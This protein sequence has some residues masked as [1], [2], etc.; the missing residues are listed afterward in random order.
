VSLSWAVFSPFILAIFVPLMKRYS[1]LHIGWLVS[2]LPLALFIGFLSY[3]PKVMNGETVYHV[4]EWIPSLGINIAFYLD[5]LSLLFAMIITGIGFFV[6]IYSIGY[7]GAKENLVNFYIYILMFMGAMLG[8]VLSN[9]L[10]VLFVFWELTSISSFLLI[11]FWYHKPESKYGAQ[12]A[13]LITVSGGLA[14]L[15][16]F[17]LIWV[18]TGSFDIREIIASADLIK[19][20]DYYLAILILF[21]LGAFTK[22]A[23]FPFHIWLPN[24]MEAPTPISAYLHSA[25]MVKAGIYMMAR[26]SLFLAGTPEW[27]YIVSLVGIFT[28]V[29]AGYMALTQTDLKAILAY[30]TISQLGLITT[31]LGF[32]TNLAI[33]TAVFHLF[34]HASFKGSLFMVVGIVDHETGTR[35]IRKLGGLAKKM[36][37]T[38]TVAGIGALA[39]AGIPPLN[40]FLSKELFFKATVSLDGIMAPWTTWFFPTMAVL[41]AIFTFAYSMRLFLKVFFGKPQFEKLDKKPH[42]API[43][44]WLPAVILVSFSV[45]FG[46]FP[47]LIENSIV[48]PA[49]SAV[50]GETLSV[51]I[52]HWHGLNL[53]LLMTII[54]IGVGTVLYINLAKFQQLQA[55][56]TPKISLNRIYDWSIDAIPKTGKII[57]DRQMTGFLRDYLVFIL[58][59]VSLSILATMFIKNTWTFTGLDLASIEIYEVLL[60]VLLVAGALGVL[61]FRTRLAAIISLGIVGFSVSLFF[62]FFRA[63]DLALTQLIVETISLALFLLAFAQL[64]DLKPEVKKW[65]EKTVNI[66]ISVAVGVTIFLLILMA[67]GNRYYEPI[68]E[69]FIENGY[70]LAGGTN[71]VNV[72]LVDFRGFDTL[73]EITVLV[74]AALSVYALIRL[75][76]EK[77]SES[78]E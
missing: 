75:R 30:S 14:M 23:Q 73:G 17:V 39:M 63:P 34:N 32:N 26:S 74:A 43:G 24:A 70:A 22:S 13:L 51:H 59:Y 60:A 46:L 35:D 44:L 33:I 71:L 49:A 38:A 25:T 55:R 50:A 72:I 10:I 7:L 18:V 20:S 19:S 58:G 57:T 21:L 3:I 68:S 2:I 40:G 15:A 54:V 28:M 42:E 27:T 29:Y 5:G 6:V 53:P 37:I 65:S 12:K 48:S 16:S 78:N 64:P 31:L 67:N 69:W 45:I 36:P 56:L 77:R 4:I 61:F 11:G 47:G 9:N 8:V 66:V 76:L 41:G 1:K 52:S 62:I